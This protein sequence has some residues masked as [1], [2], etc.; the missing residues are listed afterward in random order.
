[1][2]RQRN[3][4]RDP[5]GIIQLRD[6]DDPTRALAQARGVELLQAAIPGLMPLSVLRAALDG[7]AGAGPAG[8]FTVR[9][10][11]GHVWPVA[12]SASGRLRRGWYRCPSGC[13]RGA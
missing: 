13:V 5:A 8:S 12:I 1:M 9:G 11:C 4:T 10:G 6:F 7:T 3:P 2:T